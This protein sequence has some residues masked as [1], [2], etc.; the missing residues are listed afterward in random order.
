MGAAT[1]LRHP[2]LAHL[3]CGGSPK[4]PDPLF[5]AVCSMGYAWNCSAALPGVR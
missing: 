1:L 3:K 2:L 4:H 5:S